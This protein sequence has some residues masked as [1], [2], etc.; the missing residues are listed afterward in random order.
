[1]LLCTFANQR[2]LQHVKTIGDYCSAVLSSLFLQKKRTCSCACSAHISI[3]ACHSKAFLFE[4]VD[5]VDIFASCMGFCQCRIVLEHN[6]SR[7][8]NCSGPGVTLTDWNSCFWL[9]AQ[10]FW[11]ALLSLG[12]MGWTWDALCCAGQ[13]CLCLG[14]RSNVSLC[15]KLLS[16]G[17]QT[18]LAA[19]SETCFPFC[20]ECKC[21]AEHPGGAAVAYAPAPALSGSRSACLVLQGMVCGQ[22]ALLF[23]GG[24]SV[25]GL[26]GCSCG[27]YPQLNPSAPEPAL[28]MGGL[29]KPGWEHYL[30]GQQLLS[31]TESSIFNLLIHP[32]L[33]TT[34]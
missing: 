23:L 30:R 22:G 31:I 32:S 18:G 17:T 3:S 7:S 1:M 20:R 28:A 9:A 26:G 29:L 14:C 5:L 24:S 25:P 33:H 13:R 6:G 12:A 11:S 10:E 27:L 8:G 34:M 19:L 4:C 2:H 16:I 21:R 15:R